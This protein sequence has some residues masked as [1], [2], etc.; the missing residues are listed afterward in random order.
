MAARD[1]CSRCPKASLRFTMHDSC[2]R[3]ASFLGCRQYRA[4]VWMS[5]KRVKLSLKGPAEE[6]YLQVTCRVALS[7]PRSASRG[8]IT[9]SQGTKWCIRGSA[10]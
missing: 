1:H 9:T 4:Y 8:A 7:S 3:P 10:R 6:C 5:S 2:A